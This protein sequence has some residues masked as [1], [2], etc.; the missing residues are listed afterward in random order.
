MIWEGGLLVPILQSSWEFLDLTVILMSLDYDKRL[1]I[2][3]FW[4]SD[5]FCNLH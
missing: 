4:T 1:D 2:F 3:F 5:P